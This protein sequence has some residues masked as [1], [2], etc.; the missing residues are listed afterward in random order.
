M[1][2]TLSI[3]ADKLNRAVYRGRLEILRGGLRDAKNITL[4]MP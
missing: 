3:E 1:E 4:W 2:A